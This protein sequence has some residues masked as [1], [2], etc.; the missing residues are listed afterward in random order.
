VFTWGRVDSADVHIVP[1]LGMRKQT[2]KRDKL[3]TAGG[4]AHKAKAKRRYET[5]GCVALIYDEVDDK[6][7]KW[8]TL[9]SPG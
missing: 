8:P 9:R 6:R 5:E 2:K 1:G 3:H 7:Q 4:S